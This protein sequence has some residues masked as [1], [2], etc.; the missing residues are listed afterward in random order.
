MCQILLKTKEQK[1]SPREIAEKIS[2]NIPA[3]ECIEKVEIAGPGKIVSC[4]TLVCFKADR[5]ILCWT[6][7]GEAE[8]SS[9][10]LWFKTAVTGWIS[11]FCLGELC[12]PQTWAAA[13]NLPLLELA[14]AILSPLISSR[15]Q[16]SP[17]EYWCWVSG[18]SHEMTAKID[19][20]LLLL[21]AW[22]GDLVLSALRCWT[23]K[24]VISCC[25]CFVPVTQE[26]IQRLVFLRASA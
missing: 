21:F 10:V 14:S 24:E 11:C 19:M 5:A 26:E 1:V 18:H 22:W 7:I 12:S 15:D 9:T 25:I 2:K 6:V 17:F 16:L 3:N 4:Y 20:P 23:S 8:L 13:E